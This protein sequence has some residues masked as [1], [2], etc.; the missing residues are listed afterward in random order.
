[1]FSILFQSACMVRNRW[2]HAQDE[3]LTPS[4]LWDTA[5]FVA[6]HH[7]LKE[8]PLTTVTGKDPA[9]DQIFSQKRDETVG[10]WCEGV[11]GS[12]SRIPKYYRCLLAGRIWV[13][14]SHASRRTE[15]VNILVKKSTEIFT[16]PND[17]CLTSSEYFRRFLD[18]NI[19]RLG[20]PRC[21]R[22]WRSYSTSK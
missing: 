10:L 15:S 11:R 1:M 13:P 3:L 7:K 12:Y 14:N 22:V 9:P 17:Q 8:I 21:V 5:F 16:D 4:E 20:S 2:N 6:I 18:Q 19:H